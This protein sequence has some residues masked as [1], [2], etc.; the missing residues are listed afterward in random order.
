MNNSTLERQIFNFAHPATGEIWML[1]RVVEQRSEKPEQRELEV[2]PDWLEEK[3]LEYKK[4]GYTFAPISRM[5]KIG[6]WVCI[7]FDDGYRDSFTHALPLMKRLDVP[8]TVYVTTGFI[9]NQMPM[10]W[11]PDEEFG[12]STQELLLL[13]SEPLCTIGAHTVSHP[14]LDTLDRSKQYHE[15]SASCQQ[16]E[17]L[18]HHPLEHFSLPHGAYSGDTIEIC[19]ELELQTVVTSWGGRVRQR[20]KYLPYPRINIVQP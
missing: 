18:L 13:D 2:T 4:K 6:K 9:D 8:F 12:I 5:P 11:Y 7:T 17:E 20:K 15:I 16:L 3:I 1:H 10:W 19:Q 14:K